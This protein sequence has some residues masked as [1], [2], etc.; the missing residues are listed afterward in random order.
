[1]SL[2]NAESK[3]KVNNYEIINRLN[4]E[5]ELIEFSD[6]CGN[7]KLIFDEDF[8]ELYKYINDNVIS[9]YIEN[10]EVLYI[11]EFYLELNNGGQSI[12]K[13]V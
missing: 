11:D 8:Q 7:T 12:I 6:N 9:T 5:V 10:R 1:M 4:E 2:F 3:I 13:I